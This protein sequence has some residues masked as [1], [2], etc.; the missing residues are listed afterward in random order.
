MHI[1]GKVVAHHIQASLFD[2]CEDEPIERGAV[3]AWEGGDTFEV[4]WRNE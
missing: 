1:E 2:L 4:C 3:V